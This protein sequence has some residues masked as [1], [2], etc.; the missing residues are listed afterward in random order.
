MKRFLAFYMVSQIFNLGSAFAGEP[1]VAEIKKLVESST[2]PLEGDFKVG[3]TWECMTFSFDSKTAAFSRASSAAYINFSSIAK[4]EDLMISQSQKKKRA[5][6]QAYGLVEDLPGKIT[7]LTRALDGNRLV[8]EGTIEKDGARSSFF[9]GAPDSLQDPKLLAVSYRICNLNN[10]RLSRV[11]LNI[12]INK[13]VPELVAEQLHVHY[14]GIEAFSGDL[15]VLAKDWSG[16]GYSCRISPELAKAK[17]VDL[18]SLYGLL[19]NDSSDI[20]LGC[21]IEGGSTGKTNGRAKEFG[22][23]PNI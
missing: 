6:M 20:N 3:E 23:S 7:F 11:R 21:Y 22:L 4:S 12:Y 16:E 19:N 13:A 8:S 15:I 18:A 5:K 10:K 17:A 14:A 9:K 2:P 1:N